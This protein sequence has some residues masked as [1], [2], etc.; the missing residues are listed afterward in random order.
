MRVEQHYNYLWF[1]E[2]F[3]LGS[4]SNFFLASKNLPTEMQN[5]ITFNVAKETSNADQ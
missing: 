2:T 5:F 1:W 3:L 4:F